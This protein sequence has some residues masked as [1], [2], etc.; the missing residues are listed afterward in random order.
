MRIAPLRLTKVALSLSA[1]LLLSACSGTM[2][3]IHN[4]SEDIGRWTMG[5]PSHME[6]N[7]GSPPTGWN[8]QH[9][10]RDRLLKPQPQGL[11]AKW[12]I[13]ERNK[14][15]QVDS[16]TTDTTTTDSVT[17]YPVDGAT[18]ETTTTTTA[19]YGQLS[20]QLFF[21]HGSAHIAKDDK[22]RLETFGSSLRGEPNVALTI[23]GHASTRVN[24]TNDPVRR[25]EINFEMAQKRANA[26]TGVL[27]QSGVA[28]GMVTAVS[29]GDEVPNTDPGS[30]DQESADRRVE[31]YMNK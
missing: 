11:D 15:R 28:P 5:K 24:T 16:V 14:W 21:K 4:D 10:Y 22:Q 26:V 3:G 29:E 2:H 6:R 23:V 27:K 9:E 13:E 1:A 31:V 19:N 8:G 25:K 17:V 30:R 7:W 18:T 20:E 12:K